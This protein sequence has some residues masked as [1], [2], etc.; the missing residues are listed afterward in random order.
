M[1]ASELRRYGVIVA[2]SCLIAVLLSLILSVPYLYTAIGAAIWTF[3]GHLIT[4]DDDVAGGWNNPDGSRR[5]PWVALAIKAAFLLALIGVAFL[6]PTL[7]TVG[8]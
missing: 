4:I 8:A 2:T 5:F 6:F 1:I 3:G 7:R